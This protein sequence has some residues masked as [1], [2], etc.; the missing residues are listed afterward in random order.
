MDM[1]LSPV[2]EDVRA[3]AL[4]ESVGDVFRVLREDFQNPKDDVD[5]MAA[6]VAMRH[7]EALYQ[8]GYSSLDQM[9]QV[10]GD[11]LGMG[12]SSLHGEAFMLGTFAE[13]RNILKAGVVAGLFMAEQSAWLSTLYRM[14]GEA[15]FAKLVAESGV[16]FV[17][18]DEDD[19]TPVVAARG[20][21]DSG[22]LPT[23]GKFSLLMRSAMLEMMSTT[24]H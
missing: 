22:P 5:K 24:R 15:Y 1:H 2:E 9:A 8:V 6:Y 20:D 14:I 23:S 18:A 7:V 16:T 11:E 19:P 10:M 3:C 21:Q 17:L 13:I 4:S 12:F